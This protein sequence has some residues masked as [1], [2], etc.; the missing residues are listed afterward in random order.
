MGFPTCPRDPS[1]GRLRCPH[2]PPPPRRRRP[3]GRAPRAAIPG[4]GRRRPVR[5]LRPRRRTPLRLGTGRRRRRPGRAPHRHPLRRGL[6][7]QGPRA[8]RTGQPATGRR[9]PRGGRAAD[10]RR[11]GTEVRP[12]VHRPGRP[13]GARTTPHRQRIR[14]RRPARRAVDA[15][16]PEPDGLPP[17]ADPQGQAAEDGGRHGRHLR[18]RAGRPRAGEGRPDDAGTLR[19]CQGEGGGRGVRPRGEKRGR[20]RTAP[21]RRGGT[22]TRRRRGSGRRWASRWWRPER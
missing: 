13:R 1:H 18:Q 2:R 5:R 4:R 20:R 10:A 21:R 12:P 22:T 17:D 3:P 11:S 8:R 7:R 15:G 6:P 9:H 19:G 14:R 16:H